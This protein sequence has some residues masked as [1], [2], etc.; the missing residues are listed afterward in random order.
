[1]MCKLSCNA[2]RTLSWLDGGT[3]DPVLFVDD[4]RLVSSMVQ[5]SLERWDIQVETAP[6]LEEGFELACTKVHSLFLVDLFLGKEMGITL[7]RRLRARHM[8]LPIVMY[9]GH[10]ASHF[11][12]AAFDAGVNGYIDKRISVGHLAERIRLYVRQGK[13]AT[14][15]VRT[16]IGRTVLDQKTCSLESAGG[17]VRLTDMEFEIVDLLF[18]E[19]PELIT[20][21]E[22]LEK[23]WGVP[24]LRPENSVRSI[25]R[26]LLRKLDDNGSLHRLIEDRQD[27]GFR[28]NHQIL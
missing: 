13:R 7:V 15:S 4:D 22:I 8:H 3:V 16:T 14:S 2:G 24:T 17:A 12:S 28:F 18:R 23:I 21:R 20:S 11:E 26:R 9:T 25:M 5:A 6:T 19:R 10:V 27:Q 1:M